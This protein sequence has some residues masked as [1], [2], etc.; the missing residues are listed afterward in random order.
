MKKFSDMG[1]NFS[2][3]RV[4]NSVDKMIKVMRENYDCAAH[5]MSVSDLEKALQTKTAAEVTKDFVAAASFILS[6]AVGGKKGAKKEKGTPLW[7]P[8]Q[9]AIGQYMSQ[10]SYYTVKA[11][12]GN[13]ITVENSFGGQMHV[14]KDILEKMNSASHFGKEVPMNMT[15][16]AELLETAGDTAF[17]VSFK[18]Q[19][20]EDRVQ[21]KL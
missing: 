19:V 21:E 20:N 5:T 14:S 17:T 12:E 8:K 18:K 10:N 2:V 4:N 15:E 6:A 11:I 13:K 1:I 16:L 3:I 9:F 7:D